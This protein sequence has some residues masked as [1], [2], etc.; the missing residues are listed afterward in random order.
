MPKHTIEL[1]E[2]EMQKINIVKA[3]HNQKS[4][5]KTIS[6]IIND[7]FKQNSEYI[8]KEIKSIK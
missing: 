8:S 5:D 1:K 2:E 4:I 6:F 7:Y 3:I